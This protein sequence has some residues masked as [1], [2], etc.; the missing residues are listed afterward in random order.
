[1][2]QITKLSFLIFSTL[3]FA[4]GCSSFFKRIP[5]QA[6]G[7]HK[8]Y[9]MTL[10]GVRGN[11]SSYGEFHE[12]V[13]LHLE[14][15]DP[16]YEVVPLNLTYKTGQFDYTPHKAAQ[17]LNQKLDVA[18]PNLDPQDKIS[19][20][21]YSMGGQVGVAWYF[22]SLQDPMHRKYPLQTANF[23]SLG[24]A[25][26][27]ATEAGLFTNDI[28]TLKGTIKG[29]ILELNRTS[30]SLTRQYIGNIAANGLAYSQEK[31][32]KNELFPYIDQLR[33]IDDIK[34]FYDRRKIKAYSKYDLL[35]V[36]DRV[37]S[38]KEIRNS[39]LR[40][41]AKISFAELQALSVAGPTVTE[42]RT[43]MLA[44]QY[45]NT[46]WTSISTLVQ[47]F[48]TDLGS[49]TPGCDDFQMKSFA[50]L[51]NSFAKYSFGFK[52]RETDNAVITPSSI[53]QFTY[54]YD[55]DPNYADMK[56]TP[57]SAFR[58]S[59]NPD[60]HKVIFAETLHAT[61]ITENIYD[62]ASGYL[63]KLGKS[64][65]RLADDVV[66]VHKEKCLTPDKCDH[67]VYKF[68]LDELSDCDSPSSSC[69]KDEYKNLVKRFQR[70]TEEEQLVQKTLR[71]EL[72]GFTLELN[73][74]VP[75]GYDL[76][77]INAGNIFQFIQ[78]DMDTNAEGDHVI[79]ADSLSPYKIHIGRRL[80]LGSVLLKKVRFPGE[81]QLKINFT[82]LFTPNTDRYDYNDLQNGK[83]LKFVVNLPSLKA[84]QVEAVVSPYHSTFVDLKMAPK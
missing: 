75:T 49:Q 83:D 43:E 78:L 67:P 82:G 30:Q 63:G 12:L 71:S 50:A 69:D 64:W 20:V 46:K 68:V 14:K 16:T 84:R 62:K 37:Q 1:M 2:K 56:M 35:T 19:V 17:E 59:I 23:I 7:T 47:C 57:A 54:A 39:S 4:T 52:R 15:I 60:N 74:R 6:R 65:Q 34:N 48:E 11:E 40:D 31:I 36:L 81:D 73:L 10:H 61:L 70:P 55:L 13:K 79:R 51:N 58:P 18:I 44:K 25:Y 72:H 3:L 45:T 9:I 77:K 38:L 27:G 76:S 22:D 80:E 53:A 42:L 28:D 33:S 21:A 5:A 26:W 32:N 24:A 66:I 41:I 8:H 29:I